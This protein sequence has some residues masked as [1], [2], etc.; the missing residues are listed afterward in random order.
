LKRRSEICK[1]FQN[2]VN[3][4]LENDVQAI[5][6]AGDWFDSGEVSFNSLSFVKSV[7]LSATNIRF[8][9][10][11]GN[12]DEFCSWQGDIPPNLI[13]FQEDF[14]CVSLSENVMLYAYKNNSCLSS[15]SADPKQ[16]NLV[17]AHGDKNDLDG[18]GLSVG[19]LSY[20]NIDYLAL[21][22]FHSYQMGKIDERGIWCYCG[23][24]NGRGFDE[25]GEKG[26]VLLEIEN[27]RIQSSFV[28]MSD[29]ICHEV[30]IEMTEQNNSDFSELLKEIQSAL[31]GIPSTDLVKLVFSGERSEKCCLDKNLLYEFL[32]SF[33]VLK[34]EDHTTLSSLK[35]PS[36]T[37]I[38][39]RGEF[40]RL[41]ASSTDLTEEEKNRVA[42]LGLTALSGGSL[43]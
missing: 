15:L 30:K 41:V 19:K 16:F 17:M 25:C 12:H 18:C 7:I 23:C 22:H 36:K 24:P 1:T 10:L 21:G 27:G 6:I 13:V 26:I 40:L 11:S 34:I 9:Y 35:S 43:S 4:A 33:F 14:S 38:S 39:L 20:K 5:L 42:E 29:R 31:S 28:P 8:Y 3:Y 37:D 2:I 32:P